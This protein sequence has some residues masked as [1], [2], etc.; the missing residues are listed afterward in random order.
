MRETQR[1]IIFVGVALVALVAALMAGPATP[2]PPKEYDVVGKEFFPAFEN[3]ADAKSLE[4][5]SYDKDTAEARVFAVDFKD[6]SWR[7]PSRHNYPADGKDRLAKTA[8]SIVGI[9]RE[10]LISRQPSQ[11]GEFDVIDPLSEDTTQLTGRG[12][13]ISLKDADGK[14]LA[15]YVIGKAVPGR[16]GQFYIRPLDTSDKNVYAAKVN[17]NLSTRFTD[18]I[19]PD[20]LKLDATR[21]KSVAIDKYT[22]DEARGRLIG[23]DTNQLTRATPNDPWVLANLDPATEQLNEPEVRKLVEGL[24]NMKIVGV[25]PKPPRLS[26]DLKFDKGIAIDPATQMDLVS[27]GFFPAK[28]DDG[29]SEIYA[30]EG[31]LAA[32]TDQG[33]VYVLRFGNVFS[34]TEQEIEFGFANRTDETS[35]D[36]A[37]KDEADGKTDDTKKADPSKS[38]NRYLFVM[39]QFNPEA[40]GPKPEPPVEPK[41]FVMPEGVKPAAEGQAATADGPASASTPANTTMGEA[42]IAAAR[43]AAAQAQAKFLEATRKYKDDLRDWEDRKLEGERQVKQLNQRF[44]DWYYVISAESFDALQQGRKTLVQPKSAEEATEGRPQIP[45]PAAPVIPE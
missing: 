9:K 13:R 43:E 41:P 22:V 4:V 8:S 36:N 25:R 7:I 23:R 31:D 24:D 3:P 40:L 37:K 6:G 27:S 26:R 39:A 5:V 44:A 19:E 34:G 30:K 42:E 21:L 12:Q 15:S 35:K 29:G 1:T 16:N 14:V 17:I 33:V 28:S 20:L 18:W 10:A 11:Y 38:R 45:A 32:I 2:K